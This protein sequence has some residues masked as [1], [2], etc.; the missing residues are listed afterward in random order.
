MREAKEAFKNL[1]GAIGLLVQASKSEGRNLQ[2]PG[3]GRYQ[4]KV[5]RPFLGYDQWAGWLIIV[6]WFWMV[7]LAKIGVMPKK[8]SKLL[9]EDLLKELLSKITTTIQDAKEKE[10]NHDILALLA[11]MREILPK[12]LH[13]RLHFCATS[14]DIICTAYALQATMAFECAF[15]P[16]LFKLDKMWRDK[17]EES[18]LIVQAGRTHLQTALPVTGGFW[19]SCGHY[20]YVD[21]VQNL[22]KRANEIPGKFSGAVG[23]SASQRVL[24]DSR[25]GEDILMELLN[26]PEPG[27]STQIAPPE[28]MARFYHEMVL[29]S[30]V[31]ANLGDDTR[32][33]QSSQFG[34]ITSE[35]S[36]SSA[37]SHKKGNPIAAENVAGMHVTVIAEY[38]KVIMTLTSN[39]Q[40]D[41]RWSNVMRSYSAVAVYVFQQILT[42][43]RLLGSMKFD[44]DAC[45]ENFNRSAKLVVAELLHL[46]LQKEGVADA[47]HIVNKEIVP[48]AAETGENLYEVMEKFV[49]DYSGIPEDVW[50]RLRNSNIIQYLTSPKEYIGDAILIAE[51]EAKNK[52]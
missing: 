38:M 39:L 14:Y 41:L 33:L 47:H 9:T 7:T 27:V 11:L 4:P 19:L 23:T 22:R 49:G 50:Y 46:F 40:R 44:K 16:E 51:K 52:L 15:I 30:G 18:V 28:G 26:L 37:M 12:P 35:S 8:D 42:A 10:F 25:H 32:I 43:K 5:L 29:L 2:M 24:I 20:R 13:K 17:I 36:S 1:Y 3:D 48:I 45:H 31:L 21:T 6:E 34:E